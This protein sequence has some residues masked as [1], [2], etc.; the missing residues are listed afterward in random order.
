MRVPRIGNRL[1]VFSKVQHFIG[2]QAVIHGGVL[3]LATRQLPRASR[4]VSIEDARFTPYLE[5]GQRCKWFI[6]MT[7]LTMVVVATVTAERLPN[8]YAAL[9]LLVSCPLKEL[10]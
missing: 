1:A 5:I 10:S 4:T 7:M 3:L 9:G 2:N 6:I 8:I